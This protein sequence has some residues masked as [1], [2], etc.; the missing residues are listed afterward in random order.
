MVFKVTGQDWAGA[1]SVHVDERGLVTTKAS[2]SFIGAV[3]WFSG[4]WQFLDFR[5]A[6][7]DG[8][9]NTWDPLFAEACR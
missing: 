7:R 8:G 9:D 2:N 6:L 4:G 1:N 3:Q 5:K